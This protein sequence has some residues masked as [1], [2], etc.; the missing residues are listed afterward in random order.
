LVSKRLL[1]TD[2]LIEFFRKHSAVVSRVAEYLQEFDRLSIS[3]VTYYE[4][5]RGLRYVN[6]DPQLKALEEFAADNEILPL[7][8]AAVQKAAEVYAILRK[9][10]NLISEGDILIAG[11]A[12]ANDCS[13]VTN[14]LD[15]YRRVPGLQI[16]SW[17]IH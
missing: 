11:T 8:I 2:T 9:Q 10:G 7:D 6:I 5:L 16:E 13:L 15:H 14:N 17:S 1:D 4:V 12:L 3:I